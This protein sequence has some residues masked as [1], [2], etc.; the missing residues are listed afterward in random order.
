MYKSRGVSWWTKA[1]PGPEVRLRVEPKENPMDSMQYVGLDIHKKTIS[2]CVKQA[3]GTILKEGVAPATRAG[4]DTW[5]A[6]L[7]GPWRVAMEATLF[8]SWVYEYLKPHAQEVKVAHPAMLKAIA[9]S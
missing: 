8:T 7:E 3:D 2:Y 5:M 6:A 9:A 4:L 1:E